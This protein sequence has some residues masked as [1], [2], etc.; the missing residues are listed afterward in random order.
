MSEIYNKSYY[1][2]ADGSGCGSDYHNRERWEPFF[3]MI[4]DRIVADFAP[5]TVLDVGCAFGYVVQALRDRGFYLAAL[6]TATAYHT[7][8]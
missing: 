6:L 7:S 2:N 3:N 8:P 4:A 1:A 5:R